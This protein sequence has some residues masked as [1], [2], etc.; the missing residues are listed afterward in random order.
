MDRILVCGGGIAGLTLAIELKR[1]GFEPLV[2]ER[3]PALRREGY[4]M[5][6]F[7][8][9]W[10]VAERMGLVPALRDIHYPI[11]NIEFVDGKG[12]TY[13]CAPIEQL[14]DALDRRYT[15][16]RRPDLELILANRARETGVEIRYGTTVTAIDDKGT[17]IR[18]RLESGHEDVDA[19]V[20]ADGVH[21]RVRE[22]TFGPRLQFAR[23]LG[24]HVAAFRIPRGSFP[25]GRSVKL[26]Q[27]TDRMM[28]LY[29]LDGERMDATFVMRHNLMDIPKDQQ[30]DFLRHAFAG[31]G[32]IAGDIVDAY[33]DASPL[34][35]DS[36]T[37][38]EMAQWHK[39]RVALVGD[40]CGCLTL[41]A[42]QGSHMAM[43]GGY[44][45]AREMRKARGLGKNMTSAFSAYQDFLKPHVD[46][47][48]RQSA[49][50]A[51]LFVPTRDSWPSLRRLVI[52]LIFSKLFMRG[53]MRFFG[54]R[55]ILAGVPNA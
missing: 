20:G 14:R 37:Q 5:D 18:A 17:H 36:A 29:P 50:Y 34:Y 51:R 52:R 32:W 27:E 44:M 21:S 1:H 8:T 49:R 42:G 12:H 26:Y 30:R 15:Y 11:D 2:I 45:L 41:L 24:L 16:L 46:R 33:D 39:G 31:A 9:G 25:I 40:A 13:A 22:L 43:A 47:K 54:A 3:E 23:F 6:F 4:M 48:R 10:D 35:F 19:I 38:I 7:G 55:S 53:A 28:F